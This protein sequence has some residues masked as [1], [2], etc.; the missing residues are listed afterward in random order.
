MIPQQPPATLFVARRNNSGNF[1]FA[2]T[3][4]SANRSKS[5]ARPLRFSRS[6][7]GSTEGLMFFVEAAQVQ[8]ERSSGESVPV[9]LGD[10]MCHNV[11]ERATLQPA[12]AGATPTLR[13]TPAGHAPDRKRTRF[14]INILLRYL[15]NLWWL[16]FLCKRVLLRLYLHVSHHLS[17][18][19]IPFYFDRPS[20]RLIRTR[21]YK[22][23]HCNVA[24][25]THS[26]FT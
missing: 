14:F 16:K 19:P 1:F 5:V 22:T 20:N 7:A 25:D 23:D 11:P 13:W 2:F 6:A 9:K 10:R 8:Y 4:K 12:S 18:R 15:H 17:S 3:R 26:T 21:I 24:F